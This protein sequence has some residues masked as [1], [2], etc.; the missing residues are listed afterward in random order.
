M[1]LKLLAAAVAATACG[2]SSIAAEIYNSDGSTLAIG[3][4]VD[5]GIGEYFET[6]TK[7]HQVS[8]RVNISGTQ[9][10][11]NG[12]TVDAKGEWSLNYLEG[13]DTSFATRLGYIGATHES[14]GR[15]VIG[16]QW[17]PYY[18]VGGVADM[19]IAFAND[20]LYG[21]GYYELGSARAER[22]VS[23]RNSFEVGENASI[24]FGLGWQGENTA[25]YDT[26]GQAAIHANFMGVGLG[27]AY[28]GGDVGVVDAESHV[29]SLYYGSYGNGLY[30]A[31]VIGS[32]E[33]FYSGLEETLQ[34]EALL[35]Y[36]M[37]GVNLSVNY[38]AVEDDKANQTLYSQSALQ[39]EYNF[40]PNLTGFAAYQF[41]L[42]NDVNVAEE[43]Y[44]TLGVRYF[45]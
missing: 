31:G 7:V 30:V 39:A 6:E 24:G 13:G 12:V 3:G 25:T 18:D 16:T 19:P 10:V 44:W 8:P 40:T 26:R 11:G 42:G 27:Y 34:Y 21:T 43:D 14:A 5:V 36:A 15:L 35:A 1:K 41:D 4:Y 23:Y 28:S 17:S 29:F 38:E 2:T 9:D 20:F 37:N 45:L 32:N 33:Y 22:M